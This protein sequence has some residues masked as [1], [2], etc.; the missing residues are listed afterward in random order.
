V[1]QKKDPIEAVKASW[2]A[3]K[4]MAG[5]LFLFGLIVFGLLIAGLLCLVVG[6]IP[7][8]FTAMIAAAYLYRVLNHR[9]A[10][11]GPADPQKDLSTPPP[12]LVE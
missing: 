4:G 1:E 6:V 3:T 5:S 8:W 9:L 7:A 2:E 11:R 10:S 12:V